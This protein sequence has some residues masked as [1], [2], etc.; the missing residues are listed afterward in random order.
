M[1]LQD[2]IERIQRASLKLPTKQELVLHDGNR[3]AIEQCAAWL[4]RLPEYKGDPKRGIGLVGEK[5]GGKSHLMRC[6]S[7]VMMDIYGL[8]FP[9]K[10]CQHIVAE[11]DDTTE[12]KVDGERRVVGGAQVIER[13]AKMK[14]LCL[15]DLLNELMGKWYSQPVNVIRSVLE[16]RG[17]LMANEPMLTMFTTNSSDKKAKEVYEALAFDR[18]KLMVGAWI[19]VVPPPGGFRSTA[20][21]L[22]WRG[23]PVVEKPVNTDISYKESIDYLANRKN[24]RLK[25]NIEKQRH[26]KATNLGRLKERIKVMS[27]DQL[28]RAWHKESDEEAKAMIQ[29]LFDKRSPLTMQELMIT[30]PKP[31]PDGEEEKV[32]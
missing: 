20:N 5:G 24:E 6:I 26:E 19:E 3:H 8:G 21:V 10:K 12:V 7:Q 31:Q 29:A 17:D 28:L 14:M 32:A 25:E 2:G 1:T 16:L 11:H 4:F 22:D 13:Y 30:P 15:D 27:P 18:M 23:E 9:V